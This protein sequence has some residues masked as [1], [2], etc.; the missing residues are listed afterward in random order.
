[1]QRVKTRQRLER[2]H[3]H[4]SFPAALAIVR[5]L[6]KSGHMAVFAGG[7][8]RDSLMGFTPKDLDIATSAP[9]DEVEKAFPRT[10][11]VGK[12]F[13]TI[14]VVED[15][16][17]FEVT[18]F[19]KEGAY[20]DGRHPSEV[21]FT[22]A[23]EDASRRDFTVNALFYDPAAEKV[24]DFVGG[25]E[26]LKSRLLRTV[27]DPNLRFSEDRLRMLRA[28]R[29]VGQLGFALDAVSLAAIQQ[30][31]PN[32]KTVSAERILN[33][34]KRLLISPHLLP[35][36]NTLRLSRL[37]PHFWP[38]AENIDPSAL[39][40]FPPFNNWENAFAAVMCLAQA[41]KQIEP[42]LRAW[43]SSRESVRLAEGQIR[44]AHTLLNANSTRAERARVLG[45][46]DFA[47]VLVLTTGLLDRR[48]RRS[49]IDIWI[50]E[51]LEV[52]EEDGKL[53][54][55]FINGQDLIESGVQPGA[56]MG[57]ILKKIYDE[58][59][60]GRIRSKA[61]ALERIAKYL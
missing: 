44:G 25:V 23:E 16:H 17:N 2:L 30:L 3:A 48:G 12:A 41:E 40:S 6:Q 33:E 37:A 50:K 13:G 11:A 9:P 14:V 36:L 46:D 52:A 10:L 20:L 31:A 28:I 34:V 55:P 22:D 18:T 51:F 35:A 47:D 15:G 19:R 56:R 8:V 53:P 26:D 49:Q 29:F 61:E 59:L 7:C 21:S 27:G 24:M 42:R 5:R 32:I 1:M 4:T 60:E 45:G 39:N 54:S 43:K 38:E 57:E 58:Q